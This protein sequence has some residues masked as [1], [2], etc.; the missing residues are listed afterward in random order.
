MARV[1]QGPP[2]VK[3]I[4]EGESLKRY[5]SGVGLINYTRYN[6][7]LYSNKMYDTPAPPVIDKKTSIRVNNIS[8]T[9]SGGTSGSASENAL[10]KDGSRALTNHWNAGSKDISA[11]SF[12]SG[13]NTGAGVFQSLGDYDV[14]LKTGNSTTGSITITDGANGNIAITP[15]GTGEVDI[16]KVDINGGAIDGTTIG[17]AT[18]ASGA[19]TTIVVD[20][21]TIDGNTIVSTDTNGN[22]ILT[23]DGTGEVDISKVDIASGEI[24]NVTLG[25]NNAITQAVIDNVNIDAASIGHT[26]DTDLITLA[27]GSVTFTGSTIIPTADIN[28]GAIDGTTIGSSSATSGAF[29][30]ITASTSVDITGSAG[31]IL[32]NDETITNSTNG[33]VLINGIVSAGTGSG[34]GVFQ[35]NG[36]YD[37]TLQTGNST[38]GVITITDGSNG[39]IAITPNGTGEVDI[40]KVD[41]D[42]G[43]IDGTV[44]G[45]NSQAAGDFTAIG[46]VSAGTIVGTTI[47][48][49]TDFTIGTLIITDDQ[50]QMTPSTS[51]TVTIASAS[52]GVLNITT[53]DSAAAAANIN[54]TADGNI[55]MDSANSITLDTAGTDNEVVISNGG[56]ERFA[57]KNDGSPELDVTGAFTLDGSSS[58]KID[59]VGETE[60]LTNGNSSVRASTSGELFLHGAT[61]APSNYYACG[62]Q[63]KKNIYHFSTG[64]Q[65]FRENFTMLNVYKEPDAFVAYPS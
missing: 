57:F 15:N 32:E 46:A 63:M 7:Q 54:I 38:T 6:N 3:E 30:T 14:T 17:G 39:N 23:P 16:T 64:H 48:A 2:T 47:D 58:I 41:I 19:F 65:D 1:K 42:S 45:A 43:A 29:T 27:D 56:T 8:V 28:G 62:I 50:I 60:I 26:D 36:N 18:P 11:N 4:R 20:N 12:K 33:T 13:G 35:S 24:D 25:T 34:A 51:D 55:T 44:I 53:V 22:I 31:L 49:T 40:S 5:V 52:N 9:S 37:V 21:L 10:L 61:D 59:S